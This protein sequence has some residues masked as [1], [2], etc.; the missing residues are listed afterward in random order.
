MKYE[1]VVYRKMAQIKK[2]NVLNKSSALESRFLLWFQNWI[3][4]LYNISMNVA[5]SPLIYLIIPA[6]W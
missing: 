3:Y 5:K 2:S 6:V 1:G 4:I